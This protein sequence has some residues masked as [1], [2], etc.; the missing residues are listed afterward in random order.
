MEK[1][2][3]AAMQKLNLQKVDTHSIVIGSVLLALLLISGQSFH[4]LPSLQ[5]PFALR[6]VRLI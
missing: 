2:N 6:S 3:K 5:L 1:L 4:L